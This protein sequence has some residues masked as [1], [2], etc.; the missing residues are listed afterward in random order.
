MDRYTFRGKRNQ[1]ATQSN[2]GRTTSHGQPYR[3]GRPGRCGQPCQVWLHLPRATSSVPITS[4]PASTTWMNKIGQ[5]NVGLIEW[6]KLWSLGSMG[7]P[8]WPINHNNRHSKAIFSIP[9]RRRFIPRHRG[10]PAAPPNRHAD[11]NRLKL[12]T[13]NRLRSKDQECPSQE[14]V[15]HRVGR[16]SSSGRT[17]ENGPTRSI[18][19]TY[20]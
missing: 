2:H 8:L 5:G 14:A 9:E 12:P 19:L 10:G 1:R 15:H 20:L 13:F 17:Y 6:M 3:C 16:T 18:Y 11:W 7:P 4:S